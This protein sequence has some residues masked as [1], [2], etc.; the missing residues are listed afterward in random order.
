MRIIDILSSLE[1]SDDFHLARLLILLGAFAGRENLKE[2]EG[3][4]KLAKLDFLLR[5][6]IFLE[7]AIKIRTTEI[8]ISEP[9]DVQV[10]DYERI[11][12]ESNM[13]RFKYGPWDFKYRKLINI[14]IAKG[15]VN[16]RIENQTIILSLTPQGFEISKQLMKSES[17]NDINYR[18]K[19]LNRYFD[20]TGNHLKEFIYENF[21]E[22][23]TLK[24]GEEIKYDNGI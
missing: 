24:F 1:N 19:L 5:Y 18:A 3:L 17:F 10:A 2:M 11:S 23:I 9:I 20:L 12:I 8:K 7:R 21:P 13:V 16:T 6:P 15:L 14:L 4:T 22:V